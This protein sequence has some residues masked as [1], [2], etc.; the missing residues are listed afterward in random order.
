MISLLRSQQVVE[1]G[2]AHQ[3]NATIAAQFQ[4][5]TT[6]GNRGSIACLSGTQY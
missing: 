2:G 6:L 3:W 1:F 5:H 4:A